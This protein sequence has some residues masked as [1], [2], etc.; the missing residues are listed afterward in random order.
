MEKVTTLELTYDPKTGAV[1]LVVDGL[2]VATF[3][4]EYH[5]KFRGKDGRAA[6]A[7]A[8]CNM[9]NDAPWRIGAEVR[10]FLNGEGW[11]LLTGA[12]RSVGPGHEP[13]A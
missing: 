13:P 10:R 6:C 2:D 8:L 4:A 9:L 7:E 12:G 5:G 11:R 3:A 1:T